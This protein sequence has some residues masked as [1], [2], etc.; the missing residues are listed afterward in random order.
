M[1]D[2]YVPKMVSWFAVHAVLAS[3]LPSSSI[4]WTYV[5]RSIS[6]PPTRR[7]RARWIR[8]GIEDRLEQGLR[9]LTQGFGLVGRRADLRR[10]LA[11]GVE[12][13]VAERRPDK[14]PG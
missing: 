14:G 11:G 7:G 10:Q 8:R 2:A 3:A 12:G 4:T 6:V 5:G 13:R 1:R 9:Y